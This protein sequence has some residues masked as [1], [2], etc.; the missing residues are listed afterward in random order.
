MG[1]EG[2]DRL[3]GREAAKIWV[4][5]LSMVHDG[6][7]TATDGLLMSATGRQ[8]IYVEGL[9]FRADVSYI[10]GPVEGCREWHLSV[11]SKLA[12][13]LNLVQRKL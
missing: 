2:A 6:W 1:A 3:T 13:N 12:L 8:W 10:R 9:S 7:K 4:T 5:G 11:P